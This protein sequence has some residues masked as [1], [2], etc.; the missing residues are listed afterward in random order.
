MKRAALLLTL[1]TMLAACDGVGRSL[2]DRQDLV[3]PPDPLGC[4]TDIPSC[5][6]E[7]AGS[8]STLVDEVPALRVAADPACE[9]PVAEL[10]AREPELP[11]GE[12]PAPVEDCPVPFSVEQGDPRELASLACRALR[13]VAEGEAGK[14]RLVIEHAVWQHVH[15]AVQSVRPLIVE[16]AVAE[17]NDVRIELTGPVTLHL[18]HAELRGVQVLG[19]SVGATTPALTMEE[20]TSNDLT[21]RGETAGFPGRVGLVRSTLRRGWLGAQALD[22]E[23]VQVRDARI[24]A[25]LF[26]AD[27]AELQDV[28]LLL[29]EG[30]AVFSSLHRS[31]LEECGALTLISVQVM[32]SMLGPCTRD[33]LRA[34]SV[35]AQQSAL[36]GQIESEGSDFRD[37]WFGSEVPTQ[38][39]SWGSLFQRVA[40]CSQTQATFGSNNAITCST[41]VPD[42]SLCHDPEE[43][44]SLHL[45]ECPLLVDMPSCKAPLGEP[46]RPRPR[47]RSRDDTE[48]VLCKLSDQAL[49][50]ACVR[51]SRYI[52][53]L[54]RAP[55]PATLGSRQGDRIK[56]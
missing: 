34:Y 43:N 44:I 48:S 35:F 46:G 22:L 13:I 37:S 21:V 1:A 26:D 24:Q 14:D 12:L 40:M 47:F 53:R 50:V 7:L 45:N 32:D 27:D 6:Q 5:D 15:V 30:R 4:T 41:C 10:C 36:V 11:G 29:D 31:K 39:V 25:E 8:G 55:P 2:V 33:R 19:R 28:S 16:L 56:S 52:E 18:Q 20:G 42:A 38:L 3:G 51:P 49:G 17:L 9:G 23:S 54:L